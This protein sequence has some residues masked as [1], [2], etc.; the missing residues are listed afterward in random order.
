M[1]MRKPS[2]SHFY[3]AA[4]G[5]AAESFLRDFEPPAEPAR[6]LAGIVP[7]AGWQYS[8]AV[9]AQ[10][11]AAVRAKMR[12]STFIILGAVHRWAGVNG[13]YARGAWETPLGDVAVE[14]D[15]A[16]RIL[17]ETPDWTVDDPQVHSGEHS[18]EVELPF[19]KYL[20]PEA[21]VVPIAVNPDSRAV[22]LGRRIGE[23]LKESGVPAVVIGSSDLTHYGEPYGFT[24]AGSGPIAHRWMQEN[25][26][27]ILRLIERMNAAEVTDEALRHHNACGAGAIAATVA[28]AEAMGARHGHLLRYTTSYE[29]VPEGRFRFAVGYA[30][31]L[32]GAA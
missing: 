1:E 18:I 19:V 22:P 21:R 6:I 17:A 15:L 20:F 12:P 27:R 2:A 3:P 30:G 14:E 4:C 31:V 32:F 8:G 9:A 29:V 23:I 10:V 11:F 5:P 26:A 25:D 28:A 16:A 13:V 24:P 7:H